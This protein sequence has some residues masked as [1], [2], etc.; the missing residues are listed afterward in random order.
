MVCNGGQVGSGLLSPCFPS[1]RAE[2]CGDMKAAGLSITEIKEGLGFR[3]IL[4]CGLG[5]LELSA[6]SGENEL[7]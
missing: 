7:G 4:A 2:P 1:A 5:N 6:S 3:K